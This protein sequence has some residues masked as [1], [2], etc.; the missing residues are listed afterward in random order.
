MTPGRRPKR[1]PCAVS[2]KAKETGA[3]ELDLR[4]WKEEGVHR[5]CNIES[6]SSRVG[7]SQLAPIA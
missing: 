2:A 6:T 4:G 7:Q 3:V 1:K 5:T